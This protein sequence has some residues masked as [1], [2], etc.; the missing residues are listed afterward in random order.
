MQYGAFSFWLEAKSTVVYHIRF[1]SSSLVLLPDL[2]LPS[3]GDTSSDRV[4]DIFGDT[5][6]P[7]QVLIQ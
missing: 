3:R 6:S 2:R 7:H 4:C 1:A 5:P